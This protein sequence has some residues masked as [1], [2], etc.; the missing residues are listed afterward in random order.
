MVGQISNPWFL[1]ATNYEPSSCFQDGFRA[2]P[3]RHRCVWQCVGGPVCAHRICSIMV[4][5]HASQLFDWTGDW[6]HGG[7]HAVWHHHFFSRDVL[8]QAIGEIGLQCSTSTLSGV[9]A[10][11]ELPPPKCWL[12]WDHRR[13]DGDSD[14]FL[15]RDWLENRPGSQV[16]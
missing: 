16:P 12:V 4:G 11:S 1:I 10:C 9:W 7:R 3:C 8:S 14:I 5:S 13:L 6:L 2:L 15:T